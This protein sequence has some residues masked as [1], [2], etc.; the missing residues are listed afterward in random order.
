AEPLEKGI[1]KRLLGAAALAGG[2]ATAA[3]QFASK[4]PP[5]PVTQFASAPEPAPEPKDPEHFNG[6]G[7]LDSRYSNPSTLEQVRKVPETGKGFSKKPTRGPI[8]NYGWDHTGYNEELLPV[9][10]QETMFG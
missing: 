4:P 2:L 6:L 9:A 7:G 1:G 10:Y 3:G 5:A 8:P